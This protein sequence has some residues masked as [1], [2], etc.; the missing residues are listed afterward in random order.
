M[1]SFTDR[2]IRAARL[3][4]QLYEEVEADQ[5]AMGQ[6]MGV[7]LLS[8]VAAGIGA[9]SHGGAI[10]IIAAAFGAL[11][12]WFVWALLVYLIGTRILPQPQTQADVGQLLRTTGFS[13]SPGLLRVVGFIPV[14][15]FIFVLV[16]D[17]W[18]LVAMI[19]A[20]RQA[21]DYTSTARAVGVCL[22]GFL[23]YVAIAGVILA[24]LGVPPTPA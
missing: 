3:E 1:S 22:I 13:A 17:V 23:V 6:A 11:I 9:I 16:A 2:M 12:G 7:V 21:L 24:L 8:S 4:P 14:I 18:M 20:V 5:T 10:G 19:V 15:G